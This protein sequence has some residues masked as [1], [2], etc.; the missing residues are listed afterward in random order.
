MRYLSQRP[1]TFVFLTSV[2]FLSVGA[3]HLILVAPQ[4]SLLW[5]QK[6]G[7]SKFLGYALSDIIYHLGLLQGIGLIIGVVFYK[8]FAAKKKPAAPKTKKHKKVVYSNIEEEEV[9]LFKQVELKKQKAQEMKLPE[10]LS[11]LYHN[12]IKHY[13]N[14][15][16]DESARDKVCP[17]VTEA[18]SLDSG[19]IKISLKGKEYVLL[20][21]KNK[22]FASHGKFHCEATMQL[23][24]RDKKV[25]TFNVATSDQHLLAQWT[26]SDVE[27]FIEGEWID[28]F[29]QLQEHIESDERTKDIIYKR[30][31]LEELKS[32]FGLS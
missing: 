7:V 12:Q 19:K 5:A 14:W 17:L 23:F 15:I 13:P 4:Y 3:A 2:L 6:V 20:F 11:A 18:V 21:K 31:K 16:N 27:S 25:L 22:T 8:L 29:K 10:L 32:D 1:Y 26:P 24:A 30:K 9:A 28:D